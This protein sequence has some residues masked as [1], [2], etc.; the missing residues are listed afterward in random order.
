MR[1]LESLKGPKIRGYKEFLA[2]GAETLAEV[3]L[4]EIDKNNGLT[5]SFCA[6]TPR[7]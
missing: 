5:E 1:T 4:A 2:S 6:A 3:D 7:S